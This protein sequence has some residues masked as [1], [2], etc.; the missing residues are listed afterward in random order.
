VAKTRWSVFQ[1]CLKIILRLNSRNVRM[2]VRGFTNTS[3]EHEKRGRQRRFENQ[4]VD[5]I[6][7]EAK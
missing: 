7:P 1:K 5:A 4:R 6:K 2:I 3:A